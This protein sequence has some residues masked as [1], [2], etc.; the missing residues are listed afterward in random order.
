M[1]HRHRIG[2]SQGKLA[3]TLSHKTK[4]EHLYQH[5]KFP[6]AID[7]WA[8]HY[9][10]DELD[11]AI[12]N[13]RH[14]DPIRQAV[15]DEVWRRIVPVGG[16]VLDLACGRGFFSQRLRNALGGTVRITGIDLSETILRVAQTEQ[17]GMPFVLGNAEKLPF[18]EGVFDAILV[19]SAFEHME[20]PWPIIG[21]TYRVLKPQGYLY[22]CM[23]KSFL[24]PFIV[25]GVAKEFF[26]LIRRRDRRDT[27]KERAH[28]GYRGTLRELRR[29]LQIW[30]SEAG[31][32]WVESRALLHQLDWG[33]YKKV[34]PGAVPGLIRIGR[35][36]NRL[37]L[38]YYKNLEYWLLR[39]P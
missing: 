38:S 23:H 13:A 21:E 7:W 12:S 27:S 22:I 9:A 28:I 24:D 37:P 6:E 17:E 35:W 39:K 18:I 5:V 2:N 32:E 19:I 1:D 15:E 25:P 36:L 10:Q 34:V 3:V 11:V 31:F 16:E 30:L 4:L 20:N 33:V 8:A 14:L 29:D 26:R